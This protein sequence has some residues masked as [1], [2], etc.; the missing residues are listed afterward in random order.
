MTS[1][2]RVLVYL[3]LNII[4]SAL[5]TAAVLWAW[6]RYLWPQQ[7][8]APPPSP[9]LPANGAE[10][11]AQT[12]EASRVLA[13]YQVQPGD[14]LASIAA[15]YG[16]TEEALR[17]ANGLN[18]AAGLGVG[19]TI[20]V[21]VT[22]TPTLPAQTTPTPAGDPDALRIAAVVGAGDFSSEYVQVQYDGEGEIS[23]LGWQLRAPSGAA[24]TF[25]ALLLH[26]GGAVRVHTA[27]GTDTVVDLHWG[28][29]APLWASGETAALFSPDGTLRAEYRIP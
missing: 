7:V 24:Y 6:Q 28:S 17:A 12:P 9:A 4:V 23:L 5:T 26:S 3:L 22:P 14:S 2:K 20:F 10:P 18:T 21:P 1:R 19:Q 25:P 8:A 11:Q 29:G 15:A 16:T 27:P 13:P